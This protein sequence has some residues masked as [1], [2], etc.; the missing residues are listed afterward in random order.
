MATSLDFAKAGFHFDFKYSSTVDIGNVTHEAAWSPILSFTDGTGANAA[1]VAFT[2]E[3]SISASSS[4]NLD[5]AGGLTDAFGNAIT[6]TKIRGIFVYAAS[7]NTNNVLVGGA[8]SNTFVNWVSDATDVIVVRPGG[9]FALI[10]PDSTGYGVTAS[11]GDILKVANSSSGSSVT[12]K[13]GI[14][15]TT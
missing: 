15:G 9:M 10:A 3:R 13:I 4:E 5:L 12:Y 6:F 8:A 14:F 2:D 1:K 7:T 11:T